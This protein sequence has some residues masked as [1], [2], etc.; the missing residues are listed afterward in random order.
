MLS[1]MILSLVRNRK[2]ALLL[3]DLLFFDTDCLSAFLWIRKENLLPQLYPGKVII[4]RPVYAE[5]C[6]PN[7][8][9]L[10]SRIDVLIAQNLVSIQDI[11][12]NSDEYSTYY[13][14][15]ES[16]TEG[17]KVIGNGEAASIALAKQYGGI[18]AS[19]NLRDIQ[20]YI[21]EF[22]LQHITTGD[23]LVDAYNKRLITESDGNLIWSNML[24]KRR[25]L[26]AST[27]TE[28]LKIT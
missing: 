23:I 11:D 9:H 21:S 13:Q 6:R 14:L 18:V 17:H 28:Y 1:G 12:I 24:A 22:D 15:T 3:T 26:G 4:P 7:T 5:L 10:K 8:P 2:E 20:T 25:R 19:N 16:P 27:F